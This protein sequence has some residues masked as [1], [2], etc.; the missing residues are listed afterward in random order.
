MKKYFLILAACLFFYSGKAQFLKTGI[1]AGGNYTGFSG[2][3]EVKEKPGFYIGSFVIIKLNKK[4]SLQPELIYSEEGGKDLDINYFKIPVLAKY[5]V[6][7]KLNFQAGPQI[8]FKSGAEQGIDELTKPLDFGLCFGAGYDLF[9]D[10]FL[11]VR[12][13][14][15]LLNIHEF[16]ED[17]TLRN[18]GL[19][20]GAGYRF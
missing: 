7:E 3:A 13:N 4:L 6:A 9:K 10:L 5:Y 8:A 15:G 12:Y 1:K 17:F 16:Q 11:E 14:I 19:Q 20:L 18:K 2:D